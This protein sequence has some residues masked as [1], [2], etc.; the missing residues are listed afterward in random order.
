M[1]RKLA[2]PIL[3]LTAMLMVSC[4][5]SD[6]HA[7]AKAAAGVAAGLGT[8]QQENELLYSSGKIS[9]EESRTIAK[10]VEAGTYA[11]DAFVQCVRNVKGTS[12]QS[13]AQVVACFQGLTNSLST[14]Q[15]QALF[16]KN[17]ESQAALKLAFQSVQTALAALQALMPK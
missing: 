17:P 15:A 1:K 5:E 12:A 7:G 8:V 9:A 14:V 2:V 4:K 11:N 10:A 3:L 6:I 16:V 13:N